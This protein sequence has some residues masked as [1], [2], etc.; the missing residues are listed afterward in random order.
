MYLGLWNDCYS[1]WCCNVGGF[2]MTEIIPVSVGKKYTEYMDQLKVC[3]SGNKNSLASEICKAVK[4]YIQNVESTP[5]IADEEQ[6]DKFISESSQ[7]EL[8]EMNTLICSINSKIMRKWNQQ[9]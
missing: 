2:K 1:I 5:L 3:A 8:A 4:F 7:T 9:R 6:W